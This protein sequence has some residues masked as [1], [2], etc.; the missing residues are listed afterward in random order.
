MKKGL[1]FVLMIV[2][3]TLSAAQSY[4]VGWVKVLGF[5]KEPAPKSA[6]EFYPLLTREWTQTI[7][8][9]YIL[10]G[11]E[12]D[13]QRPEFQQRIIRNCKELV[14]LGK[15]AAIYHGKQGYMKEISQ[16][17]VARYLATCK[18]YIRT[19]NM[20]PS[21]HRSNISA[22]Q[23]VEYL[24]KKYIMPGDGAFLDGLYAPKKVTAI[25][26]THCIVQSRLNSIYIIRKI[27][28]GDSNKD[29]Y[30]D[31]NFIIVHTEGHHGEA[32]GMTVSRGKSGTVD[33]LER[34]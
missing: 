25:D 4:P 27:S 5:I 6:K 7:T 24:D 9:N 31:V 2:S 17:E 21:R 20:Q 3:L 22:R 8:V 30:E 15:K 29:G 23:L 34:W 32:Q 18:A 1:F 13:I 12:I 11:V 28:W 33:I 19:E 16:S 10:F 26:D 14:D